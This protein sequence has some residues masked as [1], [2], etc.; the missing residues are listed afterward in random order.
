MIVFHLNLRQTRYFLYK[1]ATHTRH[2]L[3]HLLHLTGFRSQDIKILTEDFDSHILLD[4][5]Q[6]LIVTHLYRLRNL[7]F[8]TRNRLQSFLHLLHQLRSSFCRRPF[9][10]RFKGNHDV[11]T[12]YRHRVCRNLCTTNAAHHLFDFRILRLQQLLCL[13]TALYHLRER[14]TL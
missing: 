13:G 11:S 10:L 12:F 5:R 7:C 8:Q 6:Q 2:T 9:C 3:Y 1:N 4:T 14:S